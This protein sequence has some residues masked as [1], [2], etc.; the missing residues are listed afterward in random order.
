MLNTTHI[1]VSLVILALMVFCLLARR[2][3]AVVAFEHTSKLNADQP[4]NDL[5]V[6]D[7]LVSRGICSLKTVRTGLQYKASQVSSGRMTG[8]TP[9]AKILLSQGAISK[10]QA[11]NA[12]RRS[13]EPVDTRMLAALLR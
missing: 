8:L 4:A 13:M 9:I 12:A 2:R 11:D 6:C 1:I 5:L 3:K 10:Q 7:F